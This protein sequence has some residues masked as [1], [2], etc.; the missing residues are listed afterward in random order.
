MKNIKEGMIFILVQLLASIWFVNKLFQLG[1]LPDKFLLVCSGILLAALMFVIFCEYKKKRM[2]VAGRIC[3]V[4]F[5]G[6]L[7][8]GSYY[9]SKTIGAVEQITNSDGTKLDNVV[10]G[11]LPEDSAESLED[12]AGDIFG[13]QYQVKGDEI[14]ET[15]DSMNQEL[16]IEISIIEYQNIMEQISGLYN[17]E[18]RAI[19]FNEAYIDLLEEESEDTPIKIIYTRNVETKV[20]V[21]PE[22]KEVKTEQEPFIIYISGNDIYGSIK[23]TSRSDV[24]I[25]AVVNPNTHQVLLITTPRDY[26]IEFPGVT[27]GAK[28]K[29]THAG[30]YGVDVSMSALGALYDIEPDFYVRVN[31]TSLVKIVDALGGVD[32]YSDYAFTTRHGQYQVV[33]GMNHFNGEQALFF[34]RERYSLPDGD[35]QRG[36]NQQAVL[37]AMIQKAVSPAI[38]V[39]ANDI[40][41][42]ISENVDTNMSSAQIQKLIKS[43]LDDPHQWTISS[44]AAEATGDRQYCYSMPGRTLYVA[45][46]NYDSVNKIK[47][48]IVRV[49][50]GEA[51]TDSAAEQ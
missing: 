16:G 21:K 28:D 26:Y 15:I 18:V 38:L 45:Q 51:L 34:C 13:V 44:V 33:K 25:L 24:N 1:M 9:V 2:R 48:E 39:G 47:E 20:E 35:F 3:C 11:V 14:L 41:E 5:S 32:V 42:S 40:L 23:K 22:I 4:I 17:G 6:I 8:F 30:I 29:L 7:L 49:K 12:I 19:I 37:T 31:F 50:S 43:Q 36:K 46:P 10:V 27:G